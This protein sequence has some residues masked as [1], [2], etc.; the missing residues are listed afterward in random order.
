MTSKL[1]LSL[2]QGPPNGGVGLV[3][4]F[5]SFFVL[6]G[7]FPIVPKGSAT[8]SG[9]FP[10]KVGN[11][12]VWKPPGLASLN[13]LAIA[14]SADPKL[15][16]GLRRSPGQGALIC[17]QLL[18]ESQMG[19]DAKW[20]RFPIGPDVSRFV[21]VCPLLSRF[22]PVCLP[23]CPD[24]SRFVPV[25]PLLSRFVPVCLPICP[26]WGPK[27]GKSGQKRTNGDKTGH[28]GTHRDKLGNAPM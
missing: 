28:I 27:R 20:G 19:V 1:G 15:N 21:P 3:L 22:V 8:Q 16:R 25:C 13:L 23:L 9:P 24:V 12:R 2:I 10:K 7:T 6:F 5:L 4:P 11:T 17:V 18:E 26:S 14:D